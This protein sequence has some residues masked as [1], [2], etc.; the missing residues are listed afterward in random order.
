[1][2]PQSKTFYTEP[3]MIRLVIIMSAIAYVLAYN[4]QLSARVAINVT[5]SSVTT[6]HR[7][8]GPRQLR[9]DIP[10]SFKVSLT[11]YCTMINGQHDLPWH[12]V[13]VFFLIHVVIPPPFRFKNRLACKVRALYA[14]MVFWWETRMLCL[15]LRATYNKCSNFCHHCPCHRKLNI[16]S[17]PQPR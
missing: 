16:G 7:D 14:D 11:H 6:C 3:L 12:C 9:H 15:N 4:V 13:M 5:D 1:M 2:Q 10:D 8:L 17:Q